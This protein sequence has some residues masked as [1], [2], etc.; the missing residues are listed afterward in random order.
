MIVTTKVTVLPEGR[1]EFFQTINPL[2]KRIRNERGCLEYRLYE[3]T[4]DENSL[5]MIEEWE[6]ESHWRE[7]RKGDNFAVMV[8]LLSVVCVPSKI[9]FKLLTQVGGNDAVRNY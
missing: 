2:T 8:G 1:K 3:E 4:G 5:I 7:H 9:D 6:A